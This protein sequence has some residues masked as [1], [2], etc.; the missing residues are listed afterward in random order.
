MAIAALVNETEKQHMFMTEYLLVKCYFGHN[1]GQ[2]LNNSIF[3][4]LC[5]ES[6]GEDTIYQLVDE[7][8]YAF[9][10]SEETHIGIFIIIG[11]LRILKTS[12]PL[13][14]IGTDGIFSVV[15]ND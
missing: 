10:R 5:E 4:I 14:D 6:C 15:A 1:W 12:V 11:R 9:G 13:P 7:R 2:M 8:I 3:K